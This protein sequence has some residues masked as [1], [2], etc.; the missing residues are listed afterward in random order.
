MI[1]DRYKVECGWI[2]GNYCII[3]K[4]RPPIYWDGKRLVW[5]CGTMSHLVEK[6]ISGKEVCVVCRPG[7]VWVQRVSQDG[8]PPP[9]AHF[10]Y[11]P[12][13]EVI[14]EQ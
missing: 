14:L 13:K 8:P 9:D 1:A 4:T 6:Q 2:D 3:F 10:F 5:K 7:S 11:L 12:W